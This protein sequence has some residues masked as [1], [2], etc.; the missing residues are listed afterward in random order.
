MNVLN[1]EPG[2][3]GCHSM[4]VYYLLL[5]NKL[6]QNWEAKTI[7]VWYFT[8]SV[9]QEARSGLAGVPLAQGQGLQLARA[10]VISRLT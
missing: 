1:T 5:H 10:T 7:N 4:V 3:L 2:T 9:G 8:L 6:A